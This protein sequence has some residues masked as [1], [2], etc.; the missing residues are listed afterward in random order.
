M[1]NNWLN[2][3]PLGL[4]MLASVVVLIS[5]NW[6]AVLISLAAIYLGSF[7]LLLQVWPFTMAAAKLVTGWMCVAILSF[8]TH[9]QKV[10]TETGIYSKRI[11]K[12]MGLLAIWVVVFIISSKTSILFQVTPEIA[13]GAFAILGCGLLQLG[14]SST[15]FKV[16]VGI[17]SVFAGFEIL[18]AGMESSILVNGLILAVDLMIAFVGSYLVSLSSVEGKE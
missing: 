15:Q 8:V 17:L 14:M 10:E 13:F 11:F 9:Y 12:L 7:I 6:R 18:Y 2:I 5:E 3:F 4:V 16:I 1:M